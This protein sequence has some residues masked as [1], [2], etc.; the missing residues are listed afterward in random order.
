MT[1]ALSDEDPEV[2]RAELDALRDRNAELERRQIASPAQKVLR[3]MR[4][5][6]AIVVLILGML[7][8]VSRE[9]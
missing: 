8:L 2:L 6:G 3:A 7:C 5:V 9:R 4:S 1:D